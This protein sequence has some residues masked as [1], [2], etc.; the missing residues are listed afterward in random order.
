MV[1]PSASPMLGTSVAPITRPISF[2]VVGLESFACA[3]T[4]AIHITIR[5]LAVRPAIFLFIPFLPL[6]TRAYRSDLREEGYKDRRAMNSFRCCTSPAMVRSCRSRPLSL[7]RRLPMYG[8][9][10]SDRGQHE[11]IAILTAE[12]RG[13]TWIVVFSVNYSFRSGISIVADQS[14]HKS[15]SSERLNR[16]AHSQ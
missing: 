11:N 8:G 5:T 12:S 9:Y 4:R 6:L 16:R 15:A 7:M 14:S 3:F 10:E 2:L 1:P 13:R